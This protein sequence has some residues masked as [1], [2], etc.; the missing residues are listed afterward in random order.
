MDIIHHYCF[1]TPDNERKSLS[2][3]SS[4]YEKQVIEMDYEEVNAS[5]P[6]QL[7]K[8][9]VDLVTADGRLIVDKNLISWATLS[10]LITTSS[11]YRK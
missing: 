4:K 10:A 1:T 7:Q 3:L 6:K 2:S 9:W 11:E 8:Y 5:D